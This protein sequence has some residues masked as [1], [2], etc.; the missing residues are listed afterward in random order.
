MSASQGLSGS[1]QIEQYRLLHQGALYGNTSVKN[2]RFLRPLVRQLAPRSILDYG[3]GRST[4]VEILAGDL[5]A[6][7]VRYDPA[8]PDY[9]APP[10]GAFDLLINVDVLEHIPEPMIDGI[11]AEMRSHA[12]NAI[13]IIDTKAASQILPNGENAHCTL[14]PHAWWRAKLL[15][16]WPMAVPIR[17]ARRTRAAFRTFPLSAGQLVAF[18][19]QRLMEDAQHIGRRLAR[20]R[21]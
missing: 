20:Q 8:I 4:L 10:S 9:S 17:V 2:L 7:F 18:N 6:R 16:H 21:G 5:G 1:E 3:C 13:I 11:L 15:E 19:G 12:E 14:R